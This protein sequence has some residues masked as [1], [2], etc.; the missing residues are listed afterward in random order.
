[1]I[2]D[3]HSHIKRNRNDQEAE[4]KRLL[5]DMERNQID[6]RVVSA[7]FGWPVKEGNRYISDFV[8]RFPDRLIGCAVVNPK[9]DDCKEAAREAMELPGMAMLEFH[10]L[11]HGY[12]PDHCGGIEAVLEEAERKK[13]PVKVFTG[14]GAC[15]LPQQWLSHVRR[16]PGLPFIF[17]HMGCFDYGYGCVELGAEYPN[18]YLETSNQYEVQILKKAVTSLPKE[19][20]V[21][22][23]SY[24]ERLTRCSLDVF[25]MFGLDKTYKE[26]LFGKNG[27]GILGSG[28]VSRAVGGEIGV[29]ES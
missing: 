25:D 19:K 5:L 17:L 4:E 7:L 13:V 8:S 14:I 22:G 3:I 1:M 12:Y 10:S 28:P 6:L 2:V 16:H 27:A 23:S 11:E 18:I 15:S 20:L 24:P 26:Y 29:Y 9:E 21:F